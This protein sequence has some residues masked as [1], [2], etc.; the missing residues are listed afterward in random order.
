M[1]RTFVELAVCLTAVACV[2]LPARRA[3][4]Q[5]TNPPPQE[6]VP[7]VEPQGKHCLERTQTKLGMNQQMGASINPLG[8]EHT[9]SFYL[10]VPL[11]RKPGALFD[12]TNVQVGV[13]NYLSPAYMHQGGFV[14]VT[15]ISPLVLRAEISGMTIWSLPIQ[16]AGYY[17]Y[18]SYESDHESDRTIERA[19][20]ASGWT[21]GMSATLRARLGRK[22]GPGLV[23]LD[24]FLAE[25]WSV[26]D[27]PVYYN[28]RRDVLAAE[29]DWILRNTGALLA[30]IPIGFDYGV[31]AGVSDWTTIV[32][33]SGQF[34]NVVLGLLAVRFLNVSA[35][36]REIQPFVI[37]GVYTHH[38]SVSQF[39]RGEAT[40]MLGASA[41]YEVAAFGN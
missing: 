2:G 10:C 11:I 39:R 16:S 7:P 27:A 23:I 18:P 24:T 6:D 19:G 41:I 28:L 14:E 17:G 9:L 35:T 1:R 32:P 40:V 22:D 30:D 31:R 33:A 12:L 5:V 25:R 8:A 36:V 38:A 29:K 15:P 37:S 13:M 20:R 4:A 26:G 34:S 3:E 21:A